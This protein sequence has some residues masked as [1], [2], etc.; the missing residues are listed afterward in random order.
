MRL[1]S[2][3]VLA[4]LA[5]ALPSAAWAGWGCGAAG[6]DGSVTRVWSIG[7]PGQA[8]RDVLA[9][10]ERLGVSCQIISCRPGV[11]TQREAHRAWPQAGRVT[12]LGGDC[13][14][15]YKPY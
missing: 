9:S 15:G 6:S 3:S 14:R 13:R 11:D 8:T 2:L 1:L 10:C 7:S 4:V 12:C 5:C